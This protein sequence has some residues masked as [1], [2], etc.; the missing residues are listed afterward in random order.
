MLA[1][2][3]CVLA[4]LAGVVPALAVSDV[5]EDEC[6]PMPDRGLFNCKR[7]CVQDTSPSLAE[8]QQKLP[9][10]F[11]FLNTRI[12]T[13]L[14]PPVLASAQASPDPALPGQPLRITLG[15]EGVDPAAPPAAT[16]FYTY[17]EAGG[18][19]HA[20][21]AVYDELENK[22]STFLP[23]PADA[24]Q[25][26]WFVRA[27]SPDDNAYTEI[28]CRV[29]SFPFEDNDCLVPLAGETT[30]ADYENFHVD[31]A[32]DIVKTRAGYDDE[33]LYL[34]ISA[35]KAPA[36]TNVIR[37]QSNHYYFGIYNAADYTN[38]DPLGNTTFA[39]FVPWTDPS[40]YC[41]G[42]IRMGKY[43]EDA[44]EGFSCHVQDNLVYF[45]VSIKMLPG[46]LDKGLYVYAGTSQNFSND[47]SSDVTGIIVDYTGVSVL[48][49][50]DRVVHVR[51]QA[52]DLE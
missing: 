19:W 15:F 48:K 47:V 35:A 4:P 33:F 18:A 32:L 51:E 39:S 14:K 37:N 40:V 3:L 41:T 29:S 21:A 50:V 44:R 24:K 45:Q 31:P 5:C 43:W 20:S 23:V 30:Y 38:L 27:V 16:V 42:L 10:G 17:G 9:T 13:R 8:Y 52:V 22:F 6:A 7:K 12:Q 2:L 34:E 11:Y 25:I 1:A 49:P 46:D 28:P 26:R 36:V